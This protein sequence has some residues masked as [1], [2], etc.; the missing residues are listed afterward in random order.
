MVRAIN[1]LSISWRVASGFVLSIAL[2]VALTA[3]AVWQGHTV[4]SAV[5]TLVDSHFV[6]SSRMQTIDGNVIRIH[7]AM[8]DVALSKSPQM[9]DTAVAA[10]PKLESAIDADLAIV[11][12]TA[13][14]P[15]ES[16][17][18]VRSAL[19]AW[20]KF[21]HQTV[22]LMRDGKAEEAAER[23]KAEGAALAKQ[24]IGTVTKV[25][26][27]SQA[28]AQ[29]EAQTT[30]SNSRTTGKL[31]VGACIAAA[32]FTLLY[33]ALVIRSMKG[34]LAQAVLMAETV[35]AG[36]LD[37]RI[38]VPSGRDEFSRLMQ[39]L[40]RM[41]DSLTTTIQRV[42][43]CSDSFGLVHSRAQPPVIRTE[44]RFA[45]AQCYCSQF[46]RLCGSVGCSLGATAQILASADLGAGA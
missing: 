30:I 24:L 11:R 15:V 18:A 22:Q 33:G 5:S 35:A 12:Q 13:V 39:A 31:M 6:A 23:T 19:D 46:E 10:I 16:V 43:S 2:L 26:E 8:K 3:A 37:V 28:K 25:V 41:N 17:D 20:Q 45:A 40:A 38:E 1:N 44:R 32:V 34:P 27:I 9:L 29:A 14:V 36:N 42:R 4:T 21:R 7:R